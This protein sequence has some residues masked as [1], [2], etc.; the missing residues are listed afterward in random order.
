MTQLSEVMTTNPHTVT[1]DDSLTDAARIMREE[2]VGAAIVTENEKVVGIV[3]DRD[4]TVR[5][6]A[7]GK[8][9]GQTA[10][11]EI[12]TS[13]PTVLSPTEDAGA[14]VRL[15]TEK[16]VRRLP[17]VDDGNPVGIV[18]LGDLARKLDPE[19]ALADI[20]AAPPND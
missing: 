7:E 12:C 15:M 13:D 18:S 9:P 14:A 19:S 17:V 2:D 10:I 20:S 11:D 16:N 4:I 3:T 1:T 6:V 5:A 8:D